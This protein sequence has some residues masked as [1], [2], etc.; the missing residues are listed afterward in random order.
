MKTIC[1]ADQYQC[2]TEQCIGKG[3]VWDASDEH[4]G[5]FAID[6]LSNHNERFFNLTAVRGK[7]PSRFL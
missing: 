7:C 4:D 1:A 6:H 3:E 5:L 2:L